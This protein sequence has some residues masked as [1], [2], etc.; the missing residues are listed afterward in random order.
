MTTGVATI[1]RGEGLGNAEKGME[2][3]QLDGILG[4][5]NLFSNPYS[6]LNSYPDPPDPEDEE[7]IQPA[8]NSDTIQDDPLLVSHVSVSETPPS[9]DDLTI[10]GETNPETNNEPEAD[11]QNDLEICDLLEE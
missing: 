5:E 2:A 6:F 7:E 3:D 9:G 11:P 1:A 10:L 4:F 8:P